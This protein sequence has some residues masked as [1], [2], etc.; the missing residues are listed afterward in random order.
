MDVGRPVE[1]DAS[2]HSD[3]HRSVL[4]CRIFSS[5]KERRGVKECGS[6]RGE[7]SVGQ[8]GNAS[9]PGTFPMWA[10]HRHTFPRLR[11][12]IDTNTRSLCSA[13]YETDALGALRRGMHCIQ[14]I[15]STECTLHPAVI[16]FV[17][18]LHTLRR[19]NGRQGA[20][21]NARS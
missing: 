21:S 15:W 13:L 7:W 19:L 2:I 20:H 16:T 14:T 10:S 6:P 5:V 8:G 17:A 12:I 3:A 1:V 9:G 18:Y 11:L 4:F